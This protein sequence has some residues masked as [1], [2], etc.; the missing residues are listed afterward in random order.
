MRRHRWR[1]YRFP[2]ARLTAWVTFSLTVQHGH[3]TEKRSLTQMAKICIYP[4]VTA[5]NLESSFM[6]TGF[7]GHCVGRRMEK[8]F[9]LPWGIQRD[10]LTRC[11]RWGPMEPVFAPC[12][13]GGITRPQSAAAIGRQTEG[14][15]S[16]TPPTTVEQ[17]FG[18]SQKRPVSFEGQIVIQS[19]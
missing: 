5:R 15:T 1:S 8:F 17:M 16:L 18:L 7:L 10:L 19:S 4:R 3:Q 14:T 11:G 2:P 6:W 12:S 13:Q 9:G